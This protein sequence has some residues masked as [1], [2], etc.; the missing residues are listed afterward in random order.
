MITR[1]YRVQ[2]PP[3]LRSTFEPLFATKARAAVAR[4]A[5]CLSVTI[6]YPSTVTPN[7]YA[8]ISVWQDQAALE[9]FN[10]TDWARPHI[11]DGM[12]QF[13]QTCWLH[14]FEHD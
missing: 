2:I 7:E 4:A 11:P 5:G 12:A 3:E 8:M 13:I 14:H 9:A 10:G 6:G 1:I